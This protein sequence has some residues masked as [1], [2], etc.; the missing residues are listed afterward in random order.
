MSESISAPRAAPYPR[1]P[2]Y[3]TMCTCGID[4]ATQHATPATMSSACAAPG[5]RPKGR[6]VPVP[7]AKGA[8]AAASG[9][10][11][12]RKKR[13]RVIATAQKTPMPK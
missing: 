10:R 8:G 1:S 6:S 4:I 9:G 11:R 2:Q 7:G 5:E 13:E 3:A 12:C